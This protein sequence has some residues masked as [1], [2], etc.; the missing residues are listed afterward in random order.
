MSLYFNVLEITTHVFLET[1]CA[2]SAF[3]KEDIDLGA[4]YDIVSGIVKWLRDLRTEK[5]FKSIYDSAKAT[6][7]TDIDVPDVIPGHGRW[8]KISAKLMRCSA[9]TIE[10][11]EPH[12]L[13]EFYRVSF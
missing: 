3:Q 1:A 13:K 10:D 4:A 8:R 5:A 6:A 11:R 12:T 7:A 9:S 2:S